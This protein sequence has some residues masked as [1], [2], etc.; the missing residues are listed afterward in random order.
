MLPLRHLALGSLLLAAA[1]GHDSP[2]GPPGEE[3]SPALSA[4]RS[5]DYHKPQL[6][7]DSRTPTE[8]VGGDGNTYLMYD[9]SVR[10]SN[11]YPDEL[12]APAPE[13]PPCGLNTNSS[14]TWV[15]I[16]DGEGNYIYGFCGFQ[17]ASD[18][19]LLWFA[20]LQGGV[21]PKQVYITITDRQTG[22]T[23]TSNR[24]RIP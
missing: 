10:N 23:Y 4:A 21:R 3:G 11:S 20:V 1:C 6:V 16:Y 22:T 19:N 2:L 18:L 12:F 17:A 7:L 9:L 5:R 13:L 15:F 24:V 14:R 8:T